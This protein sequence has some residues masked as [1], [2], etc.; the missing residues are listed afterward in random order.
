MGLRANPSLDVYNK[1]KLSS[2]IRLLSVVNFRKV[3]NAGPSNERI[4]FFKKSK[5]CLSVSV[6]GSLFIALIS[7]LAVGVLAAKNWLMASGLWKLVCSFKS[8]KIGAQH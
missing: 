2:G 1:T 7:F 6:L 5:H 3:P 4:N 8:A